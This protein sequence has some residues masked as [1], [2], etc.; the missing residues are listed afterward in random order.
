MVVDDKP[1]MLFCVFEIYIDTQIDRR[2]R[3]H[4]KEITHSTMS[5]DVTTSTE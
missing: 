3:S 1:V 4:M 5:N 2:I